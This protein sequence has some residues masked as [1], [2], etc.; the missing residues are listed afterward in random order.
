MCKFSIIKQK[1][2]RSS[3]IFLGAVFPQK[4]NFC[5]MPPWKL[6][7]STWQTTWTVGPPKSNMW[8][9]KDANTPRKFQKVANPSLKYF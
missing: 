1:K 2:C 9:D 7:S 5:A 6:I 4:I 3:D 8:L